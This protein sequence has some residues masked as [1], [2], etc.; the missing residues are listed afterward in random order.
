MNVAHP[1]GIRRLTA[2][3]R[4]LRTARSRRN[5]SSSSPAIMSPIRSTRSAFGL[6]LR[7]P[8][9]HSLYSIVSLAPTLSRFRTPSHIHDTPVLIHTPLLPLQM[10]PYSTNPIWHTHGL[11]GNWNDGLNF[12]NDSHWPKGHYHPAFPL[13]KLGSIIDQGLVGL[14]TMVNHSSWV[15]GS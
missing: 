7:S 6:I 8:L 9:P 10:W 1:H 15:L 14:I 2:A 12:F 3:D 5:T 4:R 13:E 11:V